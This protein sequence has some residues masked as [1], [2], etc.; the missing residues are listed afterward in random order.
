MSA[1]RSTT[2]YARFTAMYSIITKTIDVMI[3]KGR[4]LKKNSN[5]TE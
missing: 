5:K 1:G 3:D 2:R 4:I